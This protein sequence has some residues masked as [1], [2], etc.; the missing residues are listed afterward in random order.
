MIIQ[1]TSEESNLLDKALIL[2]FLHWYN[3]GSCFNKE[4][5]FAATTVVKGDFICL[6]NSFS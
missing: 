2:L 6:R 1:Q 4:I 3:E 5:E